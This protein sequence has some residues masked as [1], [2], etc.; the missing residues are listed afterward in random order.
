METIKKNFMNFL[1]QLKANSK[2]YMKTNILFMT[3]VLSS[4]LN[5]CLLR[6]LTVKNFFDFQPIIADLA[7][8]VIIG[9]IGYFIKPKHQFKY[10]SVWALIFTLICVINSMYYTN[11]LS[12]ASLSLLETSAQIVDV[13]DAVVENVMELKDFAYF[14]QLF[15]LF[16]VH[17]SLKKRKYYAKVTEIEVGKVRA[18]NTVVVGLIFIGF[19][20]STL[21]SVDISRLGKQWNREFIVMKF[22]I[23]TYQI[24]DVISSLQPQIS[25][26]FGY[27][28]AAKE[29]REYYDT[30]DNS[31]KTNEYTN[32]F[33]GKNLLIIH[34]ES[35]QQFVLDT[36]FNG[37]EVA[38]NLK[39]LANEGL[40]FS[41]FYAQESVGT[42]SDSEFTI[43]SSLMPANSGTVFISYWD[44]EY[45]T[46]PKLLKEKGYY[47]FSMHGNN[48]SM[49][50]RSVVHPRLGYDKFFNYKND[51]KINEVIGLGLS[52]KS[53]FKQSVP[54]IKKIEQ[55]NQNFMG[56]LLMLSNHTPWSKN[57]DMLPEFPVTMKYEKVNET[58]GE[59]ET[60][61]A[62]YMEDTKMGNYFKFVHYADQA[63]GEFIDQLDLAGLL[64]NTVIVIYGDHDAKLKKSEFNRFYNYDPYTDSIKDSTD[65]TYVDVDYYQYELNRKVPFIIW[66]KDK[67]FEKEVTQVMGMYDVQP[68]L[69]NM[70]DFHNKY[71][72]G[73]DIFSI[74]ENVVVF[75][76]GNWL[77]N[78]MYYNSQKEEGKP[79]TNEAVSIEYIQ[80]KNKYAQQ[81]LSVS[82]NIIVYDLIKKSAETKKLVDEY[83]KEE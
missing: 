7:V 70:F 74:D 66:S 24:N 52:D 78:K 30:R 37:E 65:P 22:G 53:F 40:Y 38:P 79:L 23:Y 20:I 18:L 13:A 61:E 14:W 8:V 73:H 62:P 69:G 9:A 72:L 83:S 50:N 51:Y 81:I 34:A 44:R 21:S 31:V 4:V 39:R 5:G 26:L 43:N 58:T 41:N 25:P 45:V 57:L 6:F 47:T 48:G 1:V 67:K 32:I 10:Y 49:W 46:T 42:S 63:L 12:F 15:A 59:K 54:K 17:H 77:T 3:F 27:D 60:V 33:K 19:F 76:D 71:A 11:Y 68:T 2:S 55:T 36:N 82:N 35:I 80:E 16:F 75:P 29:F 56:T 64:D 28:Q